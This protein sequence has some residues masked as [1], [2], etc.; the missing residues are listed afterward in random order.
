MNQYR[1]R[2]GSIAAA[3]FVTLPNGCELWAIYLSADSDVDY[4][5]V[6][7]S[8]KVSPDSLPMAVRACVNRRFAVV[9]AL[10]VERRGAAV[11]SMI[12]E[13]VEV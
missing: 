4:S 11:Q 7:T 9:F 1:V 13:Y 3:Q 12:D 5:I 2:Y 6:G 10:P 8:E